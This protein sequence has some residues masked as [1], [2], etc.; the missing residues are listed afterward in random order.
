VARYA[1]QQDRWI[2]NRFAKRGVPLHRLDTGDVEAWDGCVRDPAFASVEGLLTGAADVVPG[3]ASW[4][5]LAASPLQPVAQHARPDIHTHPAPLRAAPQRWSNPCLPPPPR[6]R[7]FGF[8]IALSVSC[9]ADAVLAWRKYPC[10]ACGR[11]LNGDQEWQIHLKSRKHW[12][13]VARVQRQA[14]LVAVGGDPRLLPHTKRARSPKGAGAASTSP[15][16]DPAGAG[17]SGV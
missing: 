15:P 9:D 5:L 2:R 14:A 6:P 10:A 1:R 8:R 3:R 7:P 16:S 12:K 13:N 11:D 4:C 17:S